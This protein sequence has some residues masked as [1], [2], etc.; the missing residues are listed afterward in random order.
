MSEGFE[1]KTQIFTFLK[2]FHKIIEKSLL[3]ES[4]ILCVWYYLEYGAHYKL[5]ISL[6]CPFNVLKI[7]Q[8]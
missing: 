4:N 2:A 1:K 6:T 3:P 7:K 8:K 5:K